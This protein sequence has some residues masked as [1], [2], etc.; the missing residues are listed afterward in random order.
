VVG[1]AAE[2]G[3]ELVV[4]AVDL[5]RGVAHVAP[6]HG[7]HPELVG[8]L[9]RLGDLDDLPLDSSEPK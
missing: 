3:G 1:L 5:E 2:V 8:L 9:E 6:Q 7:E 4:D